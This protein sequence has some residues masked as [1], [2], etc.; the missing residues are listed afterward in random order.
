MSVGLQALAGHVCDICAMYIHGRF[1]PVV[2]TQ[3]KEANLL[4]VRSL[5]F[6]CIVTKQYAVLTLKYAEC[7]ES[8]SMEMWGWQGQGWQSG[9]WGCSP[10][11]NKHMSYVCWAMS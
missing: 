2:T 4:W 8:V 5:C 7:P 10:R 11:Y 9:W 6:E 1:G 3:S